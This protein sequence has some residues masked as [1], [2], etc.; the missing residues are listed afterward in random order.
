ML[1]PCPAQR[2]SSHDLEFITEEVIR[3][4]EQIR[5]KAIKHCEK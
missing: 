5:N 4:A 3:Q 2:K 1:D